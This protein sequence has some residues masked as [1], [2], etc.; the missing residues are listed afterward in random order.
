MTKPGKRDRSK[1]DTPGRMRR[2]ELARELGISW[3]TLARYLYMEGAPP[4][5][6]QSSYSVEDVANFIAKMKTDA[7]KVK[8]KS[9][10]ES[11]KARL[12]CEKIAHELATERGEFISKEELAKTIVP[13]MAELGLLLKQEFELVNPSRYQGKDRVECA[14]INAKSIDLVIRRFRSGTKD[15]VAS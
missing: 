11:E 5:D 7:E 2:G 10:W 15:L 3:P 12:H 13:L 1:I 6:A 8:G 14:E 4:Q 9:Y